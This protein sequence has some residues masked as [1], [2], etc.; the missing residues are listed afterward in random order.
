MKNYSTYWNLQQRSANCFDVLRCQF[1]ALQ[2]GSRFSPQ[3]FVAISITTF[4][5]YPF[6]FHPAST[7]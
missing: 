1:L 5:I 3:S 2:I 7:E 6:Q 4:A